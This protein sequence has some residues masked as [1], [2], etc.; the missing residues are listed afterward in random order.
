MESKDLRYFVYIL[1]NP[2]NVIYV[3]QTGNLNARLSQH[4][5]SKA[6]KF[7]KDYRDFRLVYSEE[8]QTQI[9]AMRR[10]KQ[11]KGW[12]RAKKESLI[13][14]DLDLLKKL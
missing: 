13:L 2:K 3:G 11:I 5:G 1:K 10:E 14:G 8:Y 6:A 9:E 12:T 4:L 7:T